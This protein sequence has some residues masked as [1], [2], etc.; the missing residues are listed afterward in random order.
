[1]AENKNQN[2][3]EKEL[4]NKVNQIVKLMEEFGEK[5]IYGKLKGI[6]NYPQLEEIFL[7]GVWY[8]AYKSLQTKLKG[9]F[10]KEKEMLDIIDKWGNTFLIPNIIIEELKQ[11]L[12]GLK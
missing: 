5:E 7:T 11:K 2:E 9:S 8:G 10:S 6:E 1:M 3:I 12:E 4:C